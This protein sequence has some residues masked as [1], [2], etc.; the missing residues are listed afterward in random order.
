MSNLE[1]EQI[2]HVEN[3]YWADM[4]SSLERLKAN[5]DFQRVVLDGYFKDK[6]INGVSM[7]AQD[8]VIQNGH[9]PAVMEELVAIS[10]L[11]DHFITIENLGS[12]P[13]EDEESETD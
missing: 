7:L 11:E 12:V 5:K 13:S 8:A 10:H 1:D 6:A 3:V 4:W 9:R 2:L